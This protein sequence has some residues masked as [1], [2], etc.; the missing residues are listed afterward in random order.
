[1]TDHVTRLQAEID[2]LKALND[3]AVET[4]KHIFMSCVKTK[5][6]CMGCRTA[7]V[8]SNS[9]IKLIQEDEDAPP[10]WAAKEKQ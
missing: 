5:D 7:K 1:M 8:L 9:A 4:L 6:T 3:V 10:A 2:R